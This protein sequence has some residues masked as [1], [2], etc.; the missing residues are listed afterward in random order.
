VVPAAALGFRSRK[1]W[2]KEIE[3]EP[4]AKCGWRCG[5]GNP[6]RNLLC[7]PFL[8][9][10]AQALRHFVPWPW[11]T[12][13]MPRTHQS[14]TAVV[15]QMGPA[16]LNKHSRGGTYS[17]AGGPERGSP[18]N[19]VRS[20][21]PISSA[22]AYTSGFFA[23]ACCYKFAIRT[24]ERH[25]RA[26]SMDAR[27]WPPFWEVWCVVVGSTINHHDR[28]TEWPWSFVVNMHANEV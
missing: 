7:V 28:L 19:S 4:G 25:Q 9:R 10:E 24:S 27:G 23:L 13:P 5:A 15:D 11:G 2:V 14:G 6:R 26:S 21:R 18:D 22:V 12:F 8:P 20:A 1:E 17:H 16:T 3:R